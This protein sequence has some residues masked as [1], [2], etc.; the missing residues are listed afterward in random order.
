MPGTDQPRAFKTS[1]QSNAHLRGAHGLWKF[2]FSGLLLS[3]LTEGRLYFQAHAAYLI[4]YNE[5]LGNS[6]HLADL[7]AKSRAR[8]ATVSAT[9]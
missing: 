2:P 4:S 9:N 3:R 8:D 1:A 5:T 7:R 6:Y